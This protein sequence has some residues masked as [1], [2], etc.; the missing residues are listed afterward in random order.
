MLKLFHST[1]TGMP[2]SQSG[3]VLALGVMLLL[4]GLIPAMAEETSQHSLQ[5]RYKHNIREGFSAT[6]HFRIVNEE[7][8]PTP[9]REHHASTRTRDYAE[10]ITYPLHHQP[11]V[12]TYKVH[13]ER[14]DRL[15]WVTLAWKEDPETSPFVFDLYF[16]GEPHSVDS[17]A[18]LIPSLDIR[19]FLHQSVAAVSNNQNLVSLQ[20]YFSEFSRKAKIVYPASKI[21]RPDAH[22]MSYDSRLIKVLRQGITQLID[23]LNPDDEYERLSLQRALKAL[24][25]TRTPRLDTVHRNLQ[26]A[27]ESQ[28]THAEPNEDIIKRGAVLQRLINA[29]LNLTTAR[30]IR[31]LKLTNNCREP[32]NYEL[33]VQDALSRPLLKATFTFDYDLYDQILS[34]YHGQGIGEQGTGFLV[35]SEVR[36]R[37]WGQYWNSVLPWNWIKSFPEVSIE[38][39]SSIQATGE[40]TSTE[41]SPIVGELDAHRGSIPFRQYEI[42]VRNKSECHSEGGLD[43]LSYV[44]VDPELP[45]PTGFREPINMPPWVYWT[46]PEHAGKVVPHHFQT[47]DDVHRYEVFLSEFDLYGVY[48][49]HNDHKDASQEQEEGRWHFNYTYL[50]HLTLFELRQ[51]DKEFIEIRLKSSTDS[52]DAVNFIFGNISLKVGASADFLLGIGAQPLITTYNLNVYQDPL[53]YGLA[54]DADGI[55]LD[56]HDRGIGVEKVYVERIGS[57]AYKLRL[58]SHERILPVWE[59]IIRIPK[60]AL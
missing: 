32:G 26:I 15:T 56:H 23:G 27:L 60:P 40:K 50:R 9:S 51:W 48:R 57:H 16:H 37:A 42:E 11:L 46:D 25:R 30:R 18:L 22:A 36:G 10:T 1:T 41:S 47:F 13:D 4:G 2:N 44:R 8:V 38:A 5:E 24:Q 52:A 19:K 6:S 53:L 12:Y 39:L 14:L 29:V 17:L 20:A 28:G 35:S 45:V 33:E 34:R 59:G 54:Y 58:I 49:G 7:D 21:R 55:I 43:P 31:S 3:L